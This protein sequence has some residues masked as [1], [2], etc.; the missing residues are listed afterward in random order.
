MKN[1]GA[2]YV[3]GWLKRRTPGG[4]ASTG[5]VRG[6]AGGHVGGARFMAGMAATTAPRTSNHV[7]LPTKKKEEK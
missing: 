1:G 6:L 3:V 2:G 4:W 5:G 7:A